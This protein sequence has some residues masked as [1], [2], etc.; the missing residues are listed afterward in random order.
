MIFFKASSKN[1]VVVKLPTYRTSN[2]CSRLLS[3][4]LER[5]H[6]TLVSLFSLKLRLHDVQSSANVAVPDIF[7]A[8]T[9]GKIEGQ[10]EDGNSPDIEDDIIPYGSEIGTGGTVI[11]HPFRTIHG[12]CRP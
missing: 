7:L 8:K 4:C 3:K 9:I 10:I 2:S 12:L 5:K 6:C 11:N 1:L